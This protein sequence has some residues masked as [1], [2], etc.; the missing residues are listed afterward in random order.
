MAAETML[1][2]GVLV[3]L[4]RTWHAGE[5][6]VGPLLWAYLQAL[7]LA[8]LAACFLPALALVGGG[9]LREGVRSYRAAMEDQNASTT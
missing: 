6:G 5:L 4:W 2:A 7:P 1:L 3:F 9:A 8:F